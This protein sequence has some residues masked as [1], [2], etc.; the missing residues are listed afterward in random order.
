MRALSNWLRHSR[1]PTLLLQAG[2]AL[3]CGSAL[4]CGTPSTDARP[5]TGASTSGE[6]V[7]H[8]AETAPATEAT[9]NDPRFHELVRLAL[10]A[11]ERW[12]RVD[13]RARFA[14]FDCR[15]PPPPPTHLSAS[16]DADTHGEGKLY[17]IFAMDPVAYGFPRHFF[18]P[19]TA[20]PDRECPGCLAHR[21]LVNAG[22]VQVLYKDAYAPLEGEAGA[23]ASQGLHGERG[24]FPVSRDGRVFHA[25]P[26]LGAFL[27]IQLGAEADHAGTDHGFVYATATPAG[28][29]TSSGRVASCMS[30]HARE[31]DRVFGLPARPGG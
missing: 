22:V 11:H 24:L 3:A 19:A 6:A 29:I 10:Q 12:G 15:M 30:C 7:S 18:D 31:E 20:P 25:G 4:A 1:L 13:D 14:P 8:E 27:L 9:V 16:D 23:A 17:T 26:S 21:A 5:T 28:E 2:A